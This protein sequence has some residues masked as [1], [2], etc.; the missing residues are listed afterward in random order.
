MSRSRFECAD[1]GRAFPI[2]TFSYH[3]KRVGGSKRLRLR[4]G[5]PRRGVVP[6]RRRLGGR[7]QTGLKLIVPQLL[8]SGQWNVVQIAEIGEGG[9]GGLGVSARTSVL[10]V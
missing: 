5:G 7:A 2:I 4:R 10:G 9:P 6:G 3:W 1:R 8:V